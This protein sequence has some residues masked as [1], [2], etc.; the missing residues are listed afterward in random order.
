MKT[1][2][3]VDL[4]DFLSGDAH[5][6]QKFVQEIGNA[7]HEVG[8]VTVKNHG[9]D[10][11]LIEK[12]YEQVKAFFNLSL[13]TKKKYEI[14]EL[15]GQ[16]GYTS[17][18]REHAKDSPVADL[19]EF[20]HV[21]QEVTDNDP[22]KKEYPDNIFPDAELPEFRTVTLSIYRQF[23][24]TGRN[25]LRALA[26]YLNLDEFYFDKHIH[27]GNSILRPIHYPPIQGDIPEG[28]V[29]AGA[30]EDINLITLLIGA[31]ADGLEVL[32]RAG[33]WIPVT[34]LPGQIV[35]NAGDML[36]RLANNVI[37]STTH[38]VVNPPK[39]LLKT[40]R[41]SIPFFLHPRSDM[42]LSC[43]PHCITE[44][45]PKHYSDMTAGEYLNERLVELGLKK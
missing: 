26:L 20:Y 21:G 39:E 31:S 18:G 45:N 28:A 33:E 6:K 42:D 24:N 11:K 32:T 14:E 36:Q 1:I 19:K 13:E 29:R 44:N 2:P 41:Y 27:N 23:E 15:A 30:H 10:E 43:L 12:L 25:L 4:A 3:T 5:R 9:I 35:V 22:I 17:F 16:R 38:R 37:R 8:F 7:Y 40:S 34:A